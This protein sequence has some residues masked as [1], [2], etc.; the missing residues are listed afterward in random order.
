[1]QPEAYRHLA[2]REDTYW[3]YRARRHLALG[4]LRRFGIHSGVRII[5]VGCGCG[6]NLPT[7]DALSPTLVV[8]IDISPIA[9]GFARRKMP[10]A[11]L[12][13]GDLSSDLP[14]AD[15]NFDVATAFNVLY[16]DWVDDEGAVLRRIRELLR[17]GGLLLITEPALAVLRR[18]LDHLVMGKRRYNV[19]ALQ[20]LVRHSGFDLLFASYFSSFAMPFAMVGAMFH[21]IQA[22]FGT[23]AHDD[24]RS[25]DFAPL[26]TRTN[27]LLLRLALCEAN[28]I[29]AGHRM[30]LGVGIVAVLR[31]KEAP[32]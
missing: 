26:T 31:R 14:I 29:I 9:L 5:D 11:F 24:F 10:R 25:L 22:A 23:R 27:E 28:A 2:E 7:L 17:P 21:R 6:G 19:A 30:P 32:T 1:M 16:H 12:V 20:T 3:W 15:G 4:L 13:R 18:G 8:G